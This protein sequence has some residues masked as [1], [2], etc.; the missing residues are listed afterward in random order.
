M[1]GCIVCLAAAVVG[2]DV[3][4]VR[5]PEGGLQY[6]IQIA[7]EAVEALKSGQAIESDIPRNVKDIREYRITVGR[8]KLKQETPPADPP[9]KTTSND[10]FNRPLA[11]DDPFARS[12]ASGIAGVPASKPWPSPPS[13]SPFTPTPRAL[14]PDPGVKPLAEQPA[15]FTQPAPTAGSEAKPEAPAEPAP[16]TDAEKIRRLWMYLIASLVALAASLAWNA[17]LFW[18]LR[19]AR[20]RYRDLL[21]GGG[22]ESEEDEEEEDDA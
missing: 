20:R 14:S 7:P 2:V 3:G 8:E 21:A 6:Q 4:W 18:M 22:E 5:L 1:Y 16:T 15:S 11:T 17:F 12:P 13:P 10:L 19:E 9:A